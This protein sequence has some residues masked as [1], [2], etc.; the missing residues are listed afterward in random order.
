MSSCDQSAMFIRAHHIKM[1]LNKPSQAFFYWTRSRTAFTFLVLFCKCAY[2]K[3]LQ[4]DNEMVICG[5]TWSSYWGWV[6]PWLWLNAPWEIY[7]CWSVILWCWDSGWRCSP[8]SGTVRLRPSS[9]VNSLYPSFYLLS[10]LPLSNH[11]SL[12]AEVVWAY[13]YVGESCFRWCSWRVKWCV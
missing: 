11:W 5:I 3:R 2:W 4:F 7:P 8:W 12:V 10:F 1:F 6:L 9:D 13:M